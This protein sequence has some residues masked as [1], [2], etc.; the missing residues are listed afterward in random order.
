MAAVLL[1]G[2]LTQPA[3]SLGDEVGVGKVYGGGGAVK[4]RPFQNMIEEINW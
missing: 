1:Y 3:L 4:G 2:H